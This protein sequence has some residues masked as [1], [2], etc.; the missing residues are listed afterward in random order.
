MIQFIKDLLNELCTKDKCF[1]QNK[2]K[3]GV[4]Y[5]KHGGDMYTDYHSY[6]CVGCPHLTLIF[7]EDYKDDKH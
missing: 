4:C 3:Y 5:G 2:N 7:K 6:T 1:A